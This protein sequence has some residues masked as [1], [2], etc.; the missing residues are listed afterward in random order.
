MRRSDAGALAAYLRMIR[1]GTA[2]NNWGSTP[3][4][5]LRGKIIEALLH[6]RGMTLNDHDK[7]RRLRSHTKHI[8]PDRKTLRKAVDD[9]LIKEEDFK[10]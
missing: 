7:I 9:F 2:F 1:D 8:E 3:D 6:D 10:V 5:K 4:D